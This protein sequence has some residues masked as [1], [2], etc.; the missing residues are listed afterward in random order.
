MQEDLILFN[1]G[2]LSN[3]E[4]ASIEKGLSNGQIGLNLILGANKI[5]NHEGFC[6]EITNHL[7]K[8]KG[9]ITVKEKIPKEIEDKKEKE[10]QQGK[11]VIN[12]LENTN[13]SEGKH[14][15]DKLDD[16]SGDSEDMR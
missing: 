2:G 9:I 11:I 13:I 16:L 4:I 7:E 8:K 1:I 3:F 5:Y 14:S 6:K 10:N 12:N 15:R